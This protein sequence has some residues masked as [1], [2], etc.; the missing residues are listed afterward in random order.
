[1]ISEG[2]CD[3]EVLLEIQLFIIGINYIMKYIKL[4]YSYFKLKLY[5]K[6]LL[7]LLYFLN[8]CSLGEQEMSYQIY[9]KI[10]QTPNLWMHGYTHT[11]TKLFGQTS[12]FRH[13]EVD[14]VIIVMNQ[15][16]L[17]SKS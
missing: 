14:K 2:S 3:T 7:F 4:K 16:F 9:L 8:K 17:S 6:L 10:L 5:F 12:G 1:M 11:N 13:F 15:L